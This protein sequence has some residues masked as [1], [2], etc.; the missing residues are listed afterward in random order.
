MFDR[1]FMEYATHTSFV[2]VLLIGSIIA[3]ACVYN[4]RSKRKREQ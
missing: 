2:L 1:P 3:L 4:R